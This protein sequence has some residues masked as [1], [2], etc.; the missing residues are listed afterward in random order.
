MRRP[1]QAASVVV[2][3]VA[4]IVR[5]RRGRLIPARVYY[6]RF[7]GATRLCLL[8]WLL[9]RLPFFEQLDCGRHSLAG[10][11][12]CIG[13]ALFANLTVRLAGNIAQLRLGRQGRQ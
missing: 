1:F 9:C 10:N 3:V 6:Y 13:P 8:W 4:S 7:I 2:V 5:W 12:Q 11:G